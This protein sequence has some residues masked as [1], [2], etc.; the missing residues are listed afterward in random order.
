MIEG[1]QSST[2]QQLWSVTQSLLGI[3]SLVVSDKFVSSDDP[4]KSASFQ[5]FCPIGGGG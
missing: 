4:S 3:L 5:A 1:I 2:E